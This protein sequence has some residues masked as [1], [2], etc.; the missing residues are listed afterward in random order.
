[1][2][3]GET[4]RRG[5]NHQLALYTFVVHAVI[6]DGCFL[7]TTDISDNVSSQCH[8]HESQYSG[9]INDNTRRDHNP[10]AT[11]GNFFYDT[12]IIYSLR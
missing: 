10:S 6:L 8:H 4:H 3:Q 11:T 2:A 12:S 5:I 1:M 9:Y 7:G